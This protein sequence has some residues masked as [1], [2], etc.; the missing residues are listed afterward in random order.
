MASDVLCGRCG[1]P[2]TNPSAPCPRCGAPASGSWQ[3]SRPAARKNPR[4]AALLALVPGCGHFY[5][6]HNL[7]GIAFLVG[8]GGFQAID[9]GFDLTGIGALVGVPLEL[10][11]G[12]LWVYSIV[13]AYRTAK[14]T[15]S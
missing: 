1:A 5:L 4:T 15:E 9:L 2:L 13:D 14:S 8:I 12:A 11:P 3:Q 10:G 6:G 7:K